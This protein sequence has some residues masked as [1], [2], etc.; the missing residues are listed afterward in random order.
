M[1]RTPRPFDNRGVGA[2]APAPDSFWGKPISIYTRKQAIEDGVLV[3]LRQGDLDAVCKQSGIVWP[4]AC[5]SAVFNGCIDLTDAA[6]RAGCDMTGRLW[7]I[8]QLLRHAVLN[9]QGRTDTVYFDVLVVTD[10]ARPVLVK[11]KAVCGPGDRG[12]PVITIMFP[13]ED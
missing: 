1:S 11:F 6:K 2:S 8:L 12:E 10:Y 13:E 3:D 9:S 4:I 7:D 5:T